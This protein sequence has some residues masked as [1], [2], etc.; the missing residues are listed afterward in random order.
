[1]FNLPIDPPSTYFED[2]KSRLIWEKIQE[3]C[4][5]ISSKGEN[6]KFSDVFDLLYEHVECHSEKLLDNNNEY[7]E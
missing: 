5:N 7:Y 3:I 1:M 4:L 6:S 2:K